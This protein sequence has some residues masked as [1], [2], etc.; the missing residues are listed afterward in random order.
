MTLI[1]FACNDGAN[2]RLALTPG[3]WQLAINPVRG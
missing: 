3:N 1:G 2:A